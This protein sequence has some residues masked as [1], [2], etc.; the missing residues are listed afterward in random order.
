MNMAKS[1]PRLSRKN[2][3]ET[4]LAILLSNQLKST[5]SDP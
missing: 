4:L 3:I 1:P 5:K 2:T